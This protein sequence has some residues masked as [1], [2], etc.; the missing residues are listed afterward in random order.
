VPAATPLTTPVLPTVAMP[1]ALLLHVPPVVALLSVVVLPAVTVA[2][3]VI[4]PADGKGFTVTVVVA[5]A[6]HPDPGVVT[7]TVYVPAIAD[8]ILP[9][10]G[11]AL[12]EVKLEG[13]LHE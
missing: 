9:L 1:V 3:P 7:V 5:L 6:V 12:V 11:V 8:V 4:V 13:P 2:V 10:L